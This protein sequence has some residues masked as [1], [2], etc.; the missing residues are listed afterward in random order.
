MGQA[1]RWWWRWCRR[2]PREGSRRTRKKPVV[3]K[4]SSARK[5]L[6]NEPALPV[7]NA[8]FRVATFA[9]RRFRNARPS[10]PFDTWRLA[11]AASTHGAGSASEHSA[12]ARLRRNDFA[13][14]RLV[15][16]PTLRR[17]A[18]SLRQRPY[19]H[20]HVGGVHAH[21]LRRARAGRAHRERRVRLVD[22]E[23]RVVGGRR[24]PRRFFFNAASAGAQR[25]HGEEGIRHDDLQ[26]RLGGVM[27]AS[28]GVVRVASCGYVVTTAPFLCGG[29]H[30]STMAPPFKASKISN[31]GRR[32]R[33]TESE[34]FRPR[35]PDRVIR[36]RRRARRL[37]TCERAEHS[38]RQDARSARG[39]ARGEEASSSAF[40]RRRWRTS[41]ALCEACSPQ[42]NAD[43]YG[44]APRRN[45]ASA[46]A[47]R[48]EGCAD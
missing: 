6:A 5:A 41:S 30:P 47:R 27:M 43:I 2:I 26:T 40:F 11:A 42:T 22:D 31:G 21:G 14:A 16:A 39:V 44:P 46:A 34:P 33:A 38:I 32:P 12:L 13:S 9:H 25:R 18:E 17:A 20:V 8:S 10:S 48:T 28:V 19:G 24:G 7:T 45:A 23:E 37:P 15:A 29:R 1:T 4:N 35:G 3:E 36:T